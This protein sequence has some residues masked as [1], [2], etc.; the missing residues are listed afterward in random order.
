MPG[1]TPFN[2]EI[3]IID[4]TPVFITNGNIP[5]N[6]VSYEGDPTGV[7]TLDIQFHNGT[8]RCSYDGNKISDIELILDGVTL[9][10]RPTEAAYLS[11]F[12]SQLER[13]MKAEG[14]PPKYKYH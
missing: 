7:Y 4:A 5:G 14:N 2:P 12:I 13:D 1:S 9:S 8:I 6:R 10:P 3:K 11:I